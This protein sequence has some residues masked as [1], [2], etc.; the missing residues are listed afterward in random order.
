MGCLNS[1]KYTIF[2][3]FRVIIGVAQSLEPKKM[4]IRLFWHR[5]KTSHSF[6]G[7]RKAYLLRFIL[8]SYG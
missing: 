8:E 5:L 2:A 1:K 4:V 7:L 3:N 6:H